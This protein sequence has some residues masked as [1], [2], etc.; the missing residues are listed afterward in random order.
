MIS[1]ATTSK[2]ISYLVW[3]VYKPNRE[4][5]QGLGKIYSPSMIFK[6]FFFLYVG[7]KNNSPSD[8]QLN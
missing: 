1:C 4:N 6:S 2:L 5:Q 7:N 3:S 8:F